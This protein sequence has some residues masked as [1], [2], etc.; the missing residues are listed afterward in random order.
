MHSPGGSHTH[1]LTNPGPRWV[2]PPHISGPP[3]DI[4]LESASRAP[5]MIYI[6]P[7]LLMIGVTEKE[8]HPIL[9]YAT[10]IF[11]PRREKMVCGATAFTVGMTPPSSV[12]VP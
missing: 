7:V 10:Q 3:G 8:L 5:G 4:S 11:T 1:G 6:L 2:K 9:F 12:G